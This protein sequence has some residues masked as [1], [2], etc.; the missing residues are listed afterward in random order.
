VGG[1]VETLFY[2]T[3]ATLHAPT[4]RQENEGALRQDW[5]RVPLPRGGDALRRSAE[6]GREVAALLDVEEAVEGVTTGPIRPELRPLGVSTPVGSRDQLSR[7]DFAVTAGWGYTAHHGATMPGGGET[8]ERS[9]MPD[10]EAALPDGAAER[11]GTSTLDVYLNENAYWC[12]VPE[13]VWAYT[14]G[15]Y[16]VIKKWLSYR[17]QDVLGRRLTLDEVEHV[18]AMTR[19]IAALL[20]LEPQLDATY[21]A[22][23]ADTASLS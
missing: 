8:E 1:T 5:P 7:D 22:V 11:W 15:G 19:R 16:P 9:L 12:H 6:L 4:Y 21:D 3:I 23:K 20:L 14:L 17:E 2:H 13:R 18:T 10:E